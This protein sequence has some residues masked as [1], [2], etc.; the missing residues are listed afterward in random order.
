MP[1]SK[2]KR[3]LFRFTALCLLTFWLVTTVAPFLSSVTA[4]E[5]PQEP[6][7]TKSFPY[8]TQALPGQ[9]QCI[10]LDL[11]EYED[12]ELTP[13][14]EYARDNWD[15]PE[16]WAW[17]QL[18]ANQPVNFYRIFLSAAL[19]HLLHEFSQSRD[20][21]APIESLNSNDID[22]IINYALEKGWPKSEELKSKLFSNSNY[23][24]D[25]VDEAFKL[26]S[27]DDADQDLLEDHEIKKLKKN[28]R[29]IRMEMAWRYF[30]P[31]SVFDSVSLECGENSTYG[32]CTSAL[33]SQKE[34]L[35]SAETYY[36]D[37]FKDRIDFLSKVEA[38]CKETASFCNKSKD[39]ITISELEKYI[40]EDDS[41]LAQ[42]NE[43][44]I[45]DAIRK[46]GL[47]AWINDYLN[48][49]ITL[50]KFL[51]TL[52][53]EAG[54]D[55]WN[56][57]EPEKLEVE[58]VKGGLIK[59]SELA[60]VPVDGT[61]LISAVAGNIYRREE[62]GI[63]K[64]LRDKVAW[65]KVFSNLSNGGDGIDLLCSK[66][67]DSD[68]DCNSLSIS[69]QFLRS[70]LLSEP[71]KS[72]LPD[73]VH[74]KGGYFG[75][76]I[77]LASSEI[78]QELILDDSFFVR[79]FHAP[80]SSFLRGLNL[81]NSVFRD[82]I[83]LNSA[84]MGGSLF[85]REVSI[86]CHNCN[87]E[88]QENNRPKLNLEN[89]QASQITIGGDLSD[90][91]GEPK[92]NA[93]DIRLS[94][95]VL[96]RLTLKFKDYESIKR[97][98][99]NSGENVGVKPAG[100][101]EDHV[102][103][104]SEDSRD[105]IANLNLN[106]NSV[107]IRNLEFELPVSSE[108]GSHIL[109]NLRLRN[110]DK[111]NCN[112][113]LSRFSYSNAN[114]AAFLSMNRC[115]D[116]KYYHVINASSEASASTEASTDEEN[117][118]K[119]RVTEASNL[120]QPFSQ[121]ASVARSLGQ[122]SDE[123]QLFYKQKRL[124][125]LIELENENWLNWLQLKLRDLIYG[126]GNKRFR[127]LGIAFSI[128]FIGFLLACRFILKR[129]A[130]RINDEIDAVNSTL[131]K[132]DYVDESESDKDLNFIESHFSRASKV[133]FYASPVP[134][135][136]CEHSKFNLEVYLRT[137]PSLHGKDSDPGK[138]VN[139]QHKNIMYFKGK[140]VAVSE[141]NQ[142]DKPQDISFKTLVELIDSLFSQSSN[143]AVSGLLDDL[144]SSSDVCSLLVGS[145]SKSADGK[146]DEDKLKYHIDHL[147][148]INLK[149]EHSIK[150]SVKRSPDQ[151]NSKK[152]NTNEDEN[153]TLRVSL[154]K[155][156]NSVLSYKVVWIVLAILVFP[157][158]LF[159]ENGSLTGWLIATV[160]CA[161]LISSVLP[162]FTASVIPIT[163]SI[164][165]SYWLAEKDMSWLFTAIVWLL[166]AL[167]FMIAALWIAEKYCPVYLSD[168]EPS[169]SPEDA[170][171]SSQRQ[172]LGR[173][174]WHWLF[175]RPFKWKSRT[176]MTSIIFS[177][178][179]LVPI[180]DLEAKHQEFVFTHSE[181]L[182]RAF[183]VFQRVM[184][185]VLASILLPIFLIGGL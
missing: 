183:F 79:E 24:A 3:L 156:I 143:V 43:E 111:Y 152:P 131:E 50:E 76:G 31:H 69:N 46:D 60:G 145:K 77:N 83:S 78:S 106:L 57:V 164:A 136:Q 151:E 179:I 11:H 87:A 53:I 39:K 4:Q 159:L 55:S 86:H 101:E 72:A 184:A 29:N 174:L 70:I 140:Q 119:R 7:R 95:A 181:G 82:G 116:S 64:E 100:T 148:Y 48:Q 8:P 93:D 146:N 19:L 153:E 97:Y 14:E 161:L 32:E 178:D 167:V 173:Q 157:L 63:I 10:V 18:C 176:L 89:I 180:V 103:D 96:D 54:T 91:S 62:R 92:S 117:A 130:K 135:N 150:L 41:N 90:A 109:S 139:N 15:F 45:V 169:R 27:G 128:W 166:I 75:E 21:I 59:L 56:K 105:N 22:H 47:S 36:Q 182:T 35:P 114:D 162:I 81:D 120:L 110:T 126:Y 37:V 88:G 13:Q 66:D 124:E 30:S 68:F 113:S 5:A 17:R 144:F 58:D 125:T 171:F 44:G 168:E 52:D 185:L 94:G 9:S 121:A 172:D 138:P 65:I 16:R 107:N 149:E 133:L 49:D 122:Y 38:A 74:I 165:A 6:E 127:A 34:N 61:R 51:A 80:K 134:L 112:I 67:E 42:R 33:S 158:F 118:R 155:I 71:F 177:L 132:F 102:N 84:N 104:D 99:F 154:S 12:D 163:S 137:Q 85:L 123:R 1:A 160:S 170:G 142:E 141:K 115:L 108:S 98:F 147:E 25:K 26:F 20:L 73:R 2:I 23:G 175:F 129:Q 28:R 40:K